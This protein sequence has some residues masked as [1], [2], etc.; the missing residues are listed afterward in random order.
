MANFIHK[1]NARQL[2]VITNMHLEIQGFYESNDNPVLY[3]LTGLLSELTN[4]G[5]VDRRYVQEKV[6]LLFGK[7]D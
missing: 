1:M 2:A 4:P 7:G 3:A 6:N 5:Y